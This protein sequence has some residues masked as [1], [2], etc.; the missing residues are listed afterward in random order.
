MITAELP[1]Y[2]ARRSTNKRNNNEVEITYNS[3]IIDIS[4]NSFGGSENEKQINS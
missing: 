3:L 4:K 2:K 1:K